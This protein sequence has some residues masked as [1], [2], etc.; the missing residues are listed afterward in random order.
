AGRKRYPVVTADVRR[1]RSGQVGASDF[2]SHLWRSRDVRS[3]PRSLG[4]YRNG[5]LADRIRRAT[6]QRFASRL[7]FLRCR[8]LP[9]DDAQSDFVVS[10][11]GGWSNLAAHVAVNAGAVYIERSRG[12][13]R[14]LF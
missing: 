11:E 1:I 7:Q 6:R 4:C 3:E 8:R 9:K 13:P 2:E 14:I 5:V 10:S 12:I